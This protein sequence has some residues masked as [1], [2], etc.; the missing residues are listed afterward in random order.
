MAVDFAGATSSAPDH[1]SNSEAQIV[2]I[3]IVDDEPINLVVLETILDDPGYQLVRAEFADQALLA[4]L[5]HEFAV[6]IL[7]I[8][9]PGTTGIELAAIIKE[10]KKTSRI[11]IIFLTAYYNEDQHILEGYEAG[12]VDFMHKPV[13][14]AVLRS[15]VA[16]FAQLHLKQ[17]EILAANRALQVEIRTR[18]QAEERLRELNESLEARVAERTRSIQFLMKEVNHRSKNLLS[19]AQA[20][21]KQTVAGGAH[22]F[23]QRFSDRLQALAINHDL[24]VKSSWQSVEMADLVAGQLSHFGDLLG[25]RITISGPPIRLTVTAAQTLGMVLHELSTNAAKHGAL[26]NENGVI[27][28]SWTAGD[29]RADARFEL[30]WVEL[31]GPSIQEPRSRGFGTK[32][33]KDILES[34]LDAE[35]D[36]SYP[37]SGLRWHLTCSLLKIAGDA[38]HAIRTGNCVQPGEAI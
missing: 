12:A 14:A 19:V 23:S 10:R 5:K 33:V 15:K 1:V 37:A 7:D 18:Q 36:L 24:L 3:L 13:N 22:D 31:D 38:P 25:T 34:S 21:A 20:I 29:A 6:L 9:M 16:V 30:D 27:N 26:S 28:I 11:P 8:R 17:R 32:V 35:V 4:L 2:K